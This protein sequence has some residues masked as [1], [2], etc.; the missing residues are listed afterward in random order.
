MLRVAGIT[1]PPVEVLRMEPGVMVEMARVVVV[2]CPAV[3]LAKVERPVTLTVPVKLAA[4]P[5][6]CP[7]ISP[8]VMAVA[9]R[10]VVVAVEKPAEVAKSEVEVAFVVVELRAV[11]FCRVEDPVTRRLPVEV[12]PET[13]R[14][15]RVPILVREERVVTDELM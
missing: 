5:M 11:K 10:L 13:V 15:V 6:F 2:P 7:L 9:K 14:E 8:L 4:D 12:R 1:V 3:K